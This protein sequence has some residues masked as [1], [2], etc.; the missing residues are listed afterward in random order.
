M[1]VLIFAILAPVLLLSISVKY[2]AWSHQRMWPYY[3]AS[4]SYLAQ[5]V[6]M[7]V[8][9]RLV[10]SRIKSR[11]MH[12]AIALLCI[13]GAMLLTL[14]IRAVNRESEWVLRQHTFA[15]IDEYRAWMET[16]PSV[17]DAIR[18]GKR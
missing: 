18:P 10:L 15:H 17:R 9:A 4:M 16:Q 1:L 13:F 7:V 8:G 12:A 11:G 3:Y 14:G 6:L 5:V 2:Q